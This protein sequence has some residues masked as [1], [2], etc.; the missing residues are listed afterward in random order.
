MEAVLFFAV[1]AFGSMEVRSVQAGGHAALYVEAFLHLS[2]REDWH[3]TVQQL[4][5]GMSGTTWENLAH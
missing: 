5:S 4:Y 3:R 1:Q 2:H